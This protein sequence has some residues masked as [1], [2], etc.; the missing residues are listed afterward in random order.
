ME[1]ENDADLDLAV[2][3]LPAANIWGTPAQTRSLPLTVNNPPLDW[4]DIL[5]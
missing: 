3:D 4:T 1:I 2:P 5:S